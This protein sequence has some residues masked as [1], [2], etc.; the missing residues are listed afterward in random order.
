MTQEHANGFFKE[1]VPKCH[2]NLLSKYA[3]VKTQEITI[4]SA[5]KDVVD[6][7]SSDVSRTGKCQSD[8]D[9]AFDDLFSALEECKQAMKDEANEHYQSLAV[10]FESKKQLEKSQDE[11][12]A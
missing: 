4:S 5:L 9:R 1:V 8:I 12:K 11:L 3:N 2:K 6:A 7:E 10:I